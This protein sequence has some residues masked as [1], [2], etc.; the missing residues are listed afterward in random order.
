MA[1]V[2]IPT[3]NS[4][5][6][7]DVLLSTLEK[8]PPVDEIVVVDSS[9]HDRT[10]EIAKAHGAK[11]I[12]VEAQC[13]C[14]GGT[15]TLGG[16][17]AAGEIL[18]YMSQDAKPVSEDAIGRLIAPL[19]EN[20]DV[21]AAYGRQLPNQDATSF[22]THLRAF[23]YPCQSCIKSMQDKKTM[24]I[25]APF[26]SNSFAAYKRDALEEIGWFKEGI[27]MAEDTHACARMLLAGY[28]VAYA[29]DALVYHSHNY[30][31]LDEFKR[32]FDI[33]VFHRME[34]WIRDEFGKAEGEGLQYVKSE[35]QFLRTQ[36][37]L[38]LMPAS[39][40]RNGLKYVGYKIGSNHKR[41]PIWLIK[42]LSMHDR[43]WNKQ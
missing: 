10:V 8:C 18:V 28:R 36:R 41:L 9:S 13:F 2:V 42:K 23:N 19:L 30:T 6:N 37:K 27:I 25:K 33:G 39:V 3:Y 17:A 38:H 43:Y 26:L 20:Q 34:S 32:Y 4:A 1:S 40:L 31:A 5:L 29:A 7:F 15:R 24:G 21:A 16:K 12:K 35:L 11:V 14:H 22:A